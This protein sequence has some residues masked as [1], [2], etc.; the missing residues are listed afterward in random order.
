MNRVFKY[1]ACLSAAL[2][3]L[4]LPSFGQN[5][6][7]LKVNVP[8]DF[9]IGNNSLPAG[10]YVIYRSPAI[11]QIILFQS[12]DHKVS[13]GFQTI[14]DGAGVRDGA[15]QLVFRRYGAEYFLSQV[16]SAYTWPNPRQ[17]MKSPRERELLASGQNPEKVII[18]SK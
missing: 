15:S 1:A 8:F 11:P 4:A 3:L 17:L 2:M 14:A 9:V 18:V 13:V 5:Y 10:T 16:I 6:T 12:G 7:V